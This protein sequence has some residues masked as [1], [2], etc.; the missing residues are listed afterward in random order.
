MTLSP[1]RQL[2]ESQPSGG[3]GWPT[4]GMSA[5]GRKRLIRLNPLLI[6]PADLT[7]SISWALSALPRIIA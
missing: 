3:A 2:F 5:M 4:F 6:T 1:F 7:R